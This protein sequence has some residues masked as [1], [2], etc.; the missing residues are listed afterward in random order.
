KLAAQPGFKKL[1]AACPIMAVW[2]DHDYGKDDA[3]EEFPLK[4]DSK[5]QFL[6]FFGE[7]AGSPRWMYPGVYDAKIIGQAGKRVQIILL[8]GRDNRT[9]L[10]KGPR[11]SDPRFPR[12]EPYVP[13]TEASATFLGEAQWRWLEEQLRQPAEVRLICSGIQVISEDH[14]FEK[15]A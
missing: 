1:R 5:K 10:K 7:P 8:D 4:D 9:S 11:G 6:T 2:D 12:V 13:N 3:G 14:I 15:W